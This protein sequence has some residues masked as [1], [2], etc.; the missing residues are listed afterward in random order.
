MPQGTGALVQKNHWILGCPE[1][2]YR[3][4]DHTIPLEATLQRSCR[5]DGRDFD[6]RQVVAFTNTQAETTGH[7]DVCLNRHRSDEDLLSR[8]V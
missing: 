3:V 7:L 2:C 1:A 5:I 4:L 8:R 6:D